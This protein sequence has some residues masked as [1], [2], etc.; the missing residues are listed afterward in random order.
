VVN[1]RVDA[2]RLLPQFINHVSIIRAV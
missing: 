2:A 1:Q